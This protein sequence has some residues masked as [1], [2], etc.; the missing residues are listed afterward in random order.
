[1]IALQW[2]DVKGE[3]F[4]DVRGMTRNARIPTGPK[5]IGPRKTCITPNFTWNIVQSVFWI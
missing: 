3:F 1:M 5:T 2:N 4:P